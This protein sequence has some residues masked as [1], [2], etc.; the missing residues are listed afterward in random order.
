[1][2]TLATLNPHGGAAL[3]K[4]AAIVVP[5]IHAAGGEVLSRSVFREGLVGEDFP[6]FV[7]S[8]RF[9][10]AE[11]A[12]SVIRSDAYQ[13]AVVYRNDALFDVRTFVGDAV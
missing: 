11:C 13:R 7:A 2:T 12:R 3:E 5:L 8:I 1:M 4:Y 9:P 6:Q 10:N